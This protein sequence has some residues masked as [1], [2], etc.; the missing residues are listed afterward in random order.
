MQN[1]KANGL[2]TQIS[3]KVKENKSGLMVQ[4]MKVGGE[5]IRPTERVV[6]FMLMVTCMMVCGL[7]IRH[8][9][10]VFT[11]IWMELNT[12]EIGKRINNMDRVLKPGPM[13]PS[14]MV[15]MYMERSMDKVDSL[16]L[17][18]AHISDNSKKIT[19]K[20]TEHTTGL[21][22]DNLSDPGSIIKWKVM[23]HSLGLMEENTKE[24]M[25]MIKKK[26]KVLST[27]QM[28]GSMKVAGKTESSMVKEITLQ[29]VARS[30][31]EDG[32]KERDFNG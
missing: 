6:L 9:A 31:K 32:K 7:M 13:V 16:G 8:M 2:S 18:E 17:M 30:N 15:N 27:G 23:V 14:M 3:V 1:L 11:A 12:K 20:V 24:I 29:P 25:Q 21:T 4:C 10:M 22:A 26:V 19:F 5:I 28:A